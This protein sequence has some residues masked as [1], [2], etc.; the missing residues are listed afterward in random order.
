MR[1]YMCGSEQL[2]LY[3]LYRVV[4]IYVHRATNYTFIHSFIMRSVN[5]YKVDWPMGYRNLS[6]YK[7]II[8]IKIIKKLHPI[9][10]YNKFYKKTKGK[11]YQFS[12]L[13][14]IY[15]TICHGGM[16]LVKYKIAESSL[17]IGV[18]CMLIWS[19]QYKVYNWDLCTLISVLR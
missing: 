19:S 4:T 6:Q 15:F 1:L 17:T 16:H 8:V 5:P 7:S 9:Y 10:L 12:P 11:M 3:R 2:L 18:A 13:C 14:V